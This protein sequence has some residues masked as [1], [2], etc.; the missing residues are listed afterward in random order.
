MAHDA[1]VLASVALAVFPDR[2][3]RDA[4]R[5]AGDYIRSEDRP[6]ATIERQRQPAGLTDRSEVVGHTGLRSID[7]VGWHHQQR[8][9]AGLLHPASHLDS[10]R[11]IES[12]ASDDGH[13]SV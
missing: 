9:S 2:E 8:R 6:A 3:R 12:D 1:L 11:R 13:A 4:I 5:E 10:H 7:V